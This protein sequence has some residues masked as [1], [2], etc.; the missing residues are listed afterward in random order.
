MKVNVEYCDP[1]DGMEENFWMK[2]EHCGRYIWAAQWL[3]DKGCR[4]VADIACANGYGSRILA[5]AAD[6]VIAVD[7]NKTYLSLAEKDAVVKY[8]CCDLDEEPLPEEIMNIDAIV[9]FETLEHL[10]KPE[11]NLKAFSEYLSPGGTLLLSVPN[12]RYEILDEDGRN[13]DPFHLHIFS[14]DTV[15][16]LLENSGFYVEMILGQ[17]ICN[18]IVT[19]ISELDK[20]GQVMKKETEKLWPYD[21]DK[22]EIMSRIFGIPDPLNIEES[23]SHIYI[24]RKS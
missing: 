23:Y 10:R 2:V 1:F 7:R 21:R 6:Q 9:C 17:E 15:L 22:I 16:T 3:R 8:I 20:S 19:R 13:K 11:A 24:C 14:K 18:R 4:T 5:G 12:E